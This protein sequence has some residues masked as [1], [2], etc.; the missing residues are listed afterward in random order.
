MLEQE[1][2]FGLAQYHREQ[3]VFE[4]V[5]TEDVGDLARQHGAESVVGQ[6]PRRV[7]ARRAAAE[8]AARDKNLAAAR[9]RVVQREIGIRTAVG[10][11]APVVEQRLAETLALRGGQE[12]R[13]DD[14]VGVD[15]FVRQNDR[16]RA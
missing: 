4:R 7:L 10:A 3:A 2:V 1:V 13:W 9:L 6:R 5:A 14:A 16:A 12:S 8:V 11:I 15:V